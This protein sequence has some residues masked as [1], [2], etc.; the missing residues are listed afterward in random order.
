MAEE[1]DELP[2]RIDG[3]Y[4]TNITIGNQL[5]FSKK[6]IYGANFN[7]VDATEADFRGSDL[8]EVDFTGA[9]LRSAKFND[10][11]T[12]IEDTLLNDSVCSDARFQHAILHNVEFREATVDSAKFQHTDAAGADF[13]GSSFKQANFIRSNM[14]KATFDNADLYKAKFE[15]ATLEEA[16]LRGSD[17]RATS[18]IEA[19]LHDVD[20][21]E[22]EVDHETDFGVQICREYLADRRD[23]PD[24]VVSRTEANM[25]KCRE[26]GPISRP[27]DDFEYETE[28]SSPL[29]H[30][31]DTVSFLHQ[32]IAGLTRMAYRSLP[33]PP[34]D[35][36]EVNSQS[37]FNGFWQLVK[38]HGQFMADPFQIAHQSL[39]DSVQRVHQ[40]FPRYDPEDTRKQ[41]IEARDIYRRIKQVYQR[42]HVPEQKRKFNVREK[43]VMRKLAYINRDWPWL[44]WAFLRRTMHY[45]ESALKVIYTTVGVLFFSALIYPIWGL[46]SGDRII[47]YS[48][49]GTVS[50]EHIW[51]SLFF[52]LRR[53]LTASNGSVSPVGIGEEISLLETATGAILTAMLVFVLGRRATS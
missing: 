17:I 25:Q 18:F 51:V 42:S 34:S 50:I 21:R 3:L 22:V 29:T 5:D 40:K 20:L 48:M 14:R 15:A 26:R 28:Y 46:K 36:T 37:S 19:D 32:V 53:L 38:G 9:T 4:I 33:R 47:R 7:D 49:S 12:K 23:E 27:P 16:S 35:S 43:E 52:S 45:G 31:W 8:Y 11:D 41:L 39:P 10:K 2:K 44:R 13:K 6:Q 24:W 1:W 30:Y